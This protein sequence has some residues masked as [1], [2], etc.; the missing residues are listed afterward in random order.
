M[1]EAMLVLERPGLV[2][3]RVGG[4][5]YAIFRGDAAAEATAGA[6]FGLAFPADLNRAAQMG[7]RGQPGARAALRIGP[8]EV[9]LVL[10]E[11]EA[12]AAFEAIAT[13]LS[14]IAHSL[15]DVSHRQQGYLISGADAAIALNSGCP[16][17]LDSR[18]FPV[19][20]ATRTLFHKAEILLWRVAADQFRVECWRS[21][22]PY[23]EGMLAEAAKD[24]A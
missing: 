19:G 21:F 3:R 6:A 18:A 9:M 2:A 13:A 7:E 1:A 4:L 10:P 8:D 11:A 16:L 17:D 23:V 24:A 14:G 12:R 20:M 22:G 15:V 5:A